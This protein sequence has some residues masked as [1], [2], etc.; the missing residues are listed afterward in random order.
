[1]SARPRGAAGPRK[2]ATPPRLSDAAVMT[3]VMSMR[4]PMA[5]VRLVLSQVL[6]G[7]SRSDGD[8]A[9]FRGSGVLRGVSTRRGGSAHAEWLVCT[10]DPALTRALHEL[11][12]N[13]R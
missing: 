4:D 1:M 11:A 9:D 3:H 10:T 6:P 7:P 8:S 13:W 5:A 2:A 12:R